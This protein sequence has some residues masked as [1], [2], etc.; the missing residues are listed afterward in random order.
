MHA[1]GDRLSFQ[2]S[3]S[4]SAGTVQ[5]V[6][7]NAADT[8]AVARFTPPAGFNG[9]ATFAYTARDS[10]GLTS[11]PATVTV[12]VG[13]AATGGTGG[14]GGT[15]GGGTTGGGTTTVKATV[16]LKPSF[17]LVH[18]GARTFLAVKG[19]LPKSQAGRLVR[20]QRKSGRKI[21]TIGAVR[22]AKTGRFARA[23]PVH[24]HAL[25]VRASLGSN[26]RT[27]AARSSFRRVTG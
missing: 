7:A 11:K 4:P 8:K 5:I 25:S 16:R 24:A 23:I 15:T 9:T 12:T 3:G 10:R 21:T 20:V 6:D 13:S 19:T 2:A 18:S 14:T 22:V 26:A 27:K 1:D 17:R